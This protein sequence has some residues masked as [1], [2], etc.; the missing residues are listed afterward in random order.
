MYLEHFGLTV[1]PFGV[2][3]RLDF[4]YKSGAFEESMAHLVYGLD[5]N[6]A[7]ILITGAI[8]TGKTMAIQSFLSYLGDR[9]VSA[10]I[11]NT[12]VDGKELLKL[13]LDDLGVPTEGPADKSDLLIAFKKLTI[14][15]GRAGKRI[16][17]VVDEAQ[18]LAQGVL[19]EIRQLTNVGQGT[20]QPVQVV[21]VGQPELEATV[22]QPG[23]AQLAQRIRVR[24][25][26]EALSRRELEEYIDHRLRVAGGK[27]GIFSKGALDQVFSLS[28]GVPR[29]V[30]ALCDRALLSAFVAGRHNVDVDDLDEAERPSVDNDDS[31]SVTAPEIP[32]GAPIAAHLTPPPQAEQR[33]AMASR[34]E[35]SPP[36]LALKRGR[37][38]EA[39]AAGAGRERNRP[40]SRRGLAITMAVIVVA[41]ALVVGATRLRSV[42][43]GRSPQARVTGE[44]AGPAAF[45]PARESGL[46]GAPGTGEAVDGASPTVAPATTDSAATPG[47][48]DG[49]PRASA[50][51]VSSGSGMAESAAQQS[52]RTETDASAAAEVAAGVPVAPAAEGVATGDGDYYIHVSSFR[53]DEHAQSVAR[54]FMADGIPARVHS[55][56]VREQLWYRVYLGPL[57]NR[58]E[59]EALT[60]RLRDEG[61]ITYS[62]MI[63]GG[64]GEGL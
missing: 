11:T 55:Q 29:V 30:N 12:C 31:R 47:A 6:E 51:P 7:I 36:P 18:N 23:L 19:E 50:V 53:T 5:N 8:G 14:D 48:E 45:P 43:P 60:T 59:A 15:A 49:S 44:P 2:S 33:P 52:A 40:G 16:I 41:A 39:R 24:Y 38:R 3:P 35:V 9:Y 1:N 13:I 61:R 56:M 54:S 10:F 63:H 62:K 58:V 21:L 42:F 26:L 22:R 28:G 34:K 37:V 32:S 27:A 17:I 46:A 57:A 20:E 25:K 64:A 4:L